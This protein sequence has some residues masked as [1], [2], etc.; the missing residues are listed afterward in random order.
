MHTQEEGEKAILVCVAYTN[1]AGVVERRKRGM[2][3]ERR[4]AG[5]RKP[6]GITWTKHLIVCTDKSEYTLPR[7][8]ACTADGE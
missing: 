1:E 7:L 8:G 5:E 3:M 4:A 2:D 6:S